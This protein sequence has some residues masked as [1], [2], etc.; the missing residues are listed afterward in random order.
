MNKVKQ[1][2]HYTAFVFHVGALQRVLMPF[3]I[4]HSLAFLWKV[5]HYFLSRFKWRYVSSIWMTWSSFKTPRTTIFVTLMSTWNPQRR[6]ESSWRLKWHFFQF[7]VYY[8]GRMAT[9]GCLEIYKTNLA[10]L[11]EDHQN[12]NKA[13]QRSFLELRYVYCIFIDDL[14]G[15][16]HPL[17]NS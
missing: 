1:G 9:Y 5:L 15:L 14:K 10:L 13:K 2:R 17:K 7:Q 11:Q 8:L 6:K 16:A 12:S 3:R 4:I